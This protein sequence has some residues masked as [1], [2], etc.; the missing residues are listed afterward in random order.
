[1]AKTILKYVCNGKELPAHNELR[2]YDDA[3]LRNQET[4][5][6]YVIFSPPFIIIII[7]PPHLFLLL[8][9]LDDVYVWRCCLL[10]YALFHTLSISDFYYA[11]NFRMRIVRTY[12]YTLLHSYAE[13]YHNRM[14]CTMGCMC[15]AD[16]NS[17]LCRMY[18]LFQ[19]V[20]SKWIST[21]MS[22]NAPNQ[23]VV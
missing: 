4:S 7:H 2:K 17:L 22:N 14:R 6:F 3:N 11:H 8:V 13:K 10:V 19:S 20:K 5:S 18:D 9:F 16:S 1:M 23:I 12:R 21:I 15:V